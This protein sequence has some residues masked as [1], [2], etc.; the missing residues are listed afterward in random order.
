MGAATQEVVVSNPAGIWSFFS[1]SFLSFPLSLHNKLV[2]G[3]KSGTSRKSISTNYKVNKLVVL[4][5]LLRV[6][7]KLN[8]FF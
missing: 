2:E 6:G 7:N 5:V 3:P 8:N 4:A 1:F